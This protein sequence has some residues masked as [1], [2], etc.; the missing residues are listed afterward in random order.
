MNE[1]TITQTLQADEF[2][3]LLYNCW[4]YS[5]YWC[6]IDC[7]PAFDWYNATYPETSDLPC[8]EDK[9]WA[10]LKHDPSHRIEVHDTYSDEKFSLRWDMI[11]EGSKTFVQDFPRHYQDF[12]SEN[13]DAVTADV[14]LQCVCLGD[15][16]YG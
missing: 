5:N 6:S 9:L 15:V 14:W 8:I 1:I 10:Y 16:E 13:D 2:K 7:D 4:H 12:V 3:N 11:L